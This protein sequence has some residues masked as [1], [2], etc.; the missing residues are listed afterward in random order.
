MYT[1][2]VG[3]YLYEPL[4]LKFVSTLS[5]SE[6][7]FSISSNLLSQCVN[8]IEDIIHRC[9]SFQMSP[10]LPIYFIEHSINILL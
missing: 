6:S 5:K 4:Y 10:A 8:V 7:A 3:D 2:E 1:T 9:N